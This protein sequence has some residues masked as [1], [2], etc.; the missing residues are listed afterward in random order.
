MKYLQLL[1]NSYA[2]ACRHNEWPPQDHLDYIGEGIF[3]FET[4]NSRMSSLF[5]QKALEVCET[6]TAGSVTD[7]IKD[8]D[9]YLWYLIMRNMPF[10]MSKTNQ[11]GSPSTAGWDSEIIL[12]CGGLWNGDEPMDE[13]FTFTIQTWT[14]FLSDVSEFARE[15]S[16]T[17]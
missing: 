10:F 2:A 5:A 17:E 13:E 9:N 7:Y 3:G 11:V 4:C 8:E 1:R 15:K 14:E 6:L 16:K 12:Q